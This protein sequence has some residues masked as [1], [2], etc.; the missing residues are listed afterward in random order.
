MKIQF[1]NRQE[2]ETALHIHFDRWS[3]WG[4][5]TGK[6]DIGYADM[7]IAYEDPSMGQRAVDAWKS[8]RFLTVGFDQLPI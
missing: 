7:T 8:A 5:S 4:L 2:F 3:I 1:H 6:V